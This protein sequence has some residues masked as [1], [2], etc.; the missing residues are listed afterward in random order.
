MSEIRKHSNAAWRIA[1]QYSA[2]LASET[3]DLAATIDALI[4]ECAT[5]GA[6][7]CD[8]HHKPAIGTEVSKQIRKLAGTST[9]PPAD[10]K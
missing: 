6:V 7:T 3:R 9:L 10:G 1:S 2:V 4:D 8:M 5:I